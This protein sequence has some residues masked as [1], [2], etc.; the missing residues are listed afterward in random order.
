MEG[1]PAQVLTP[2][3]EARCYSLAYP[4]WPDALM[5]SRLLAEEL[6]DA[7]ADAQLL[8]LGPPPPRAGL[9]EPCPA[10]L[11]QTGPMALPPAALLG[12]AMPSGC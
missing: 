3:Q 11:P 7:S 2:F 6:G 9:P 4:H 10:P 1:T 12:Q 8:D 5:L